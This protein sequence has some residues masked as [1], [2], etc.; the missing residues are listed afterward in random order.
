[1]KSTMQS[2]ALTLTAV[3]HAISDSFGDGQALTCRNEEG[4]VERL[5][6]DELVL[7]TARLA[8][9]L[10]ALNVMRGDRIGTLMWNSGQHLEAYLAIPC[11]GAVLHTLNVRLTAEQLAFVVTDAGDRVVLCDSSLAS[12][13]AAAI[14]AMPTVES[15][16]VVGDL[17]AV[18]RSTFEAAGKTVVDYADA[19]AS[20]ADSYQWP[21]L[22]EH[23]AASL[24]YTSGTTGDPKGVVYSHRSVYLHALAACSGN[25]AGICARDTVMPLVPMFHVNA[26]GLPYAALMAGADLV[27][28]HRFVRPATIAALVEGWK[29]TVAG[30]VP[31]VFNDLLGWLRENPGHDLTSLRRVFCGGAAVPIALI[32]AYRSEFGVTITQAWG[33]TETSPIVCVADPPKGCGPEQARGYAQAAGRVVFGSRGRIVGDDG[34]VLPR[35]GISVGEFQVSGPWITGQYL[36]GRNAES[37]ERSEDGTV[38]LR[39][40]DI[41]RINHLGYVQLTDRAKDVIKSGGE[42]ISSVELETAL[43]GHP[44]VIEAAVIGVPDSRWDERPLAVVVRSH[45]SD[46]SEAELQEWLSHRVVKWWLPERWSFVDAL[47]RTGTGKTDKRALRAR[48]AANDLLVTTLSPGSAF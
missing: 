27:L 7:R 20:A 6:Y 36:G 15:V 3:L 21:L 46:V 45:G 11:Y 16:V 4:D 37:F 47:Q 26:W 25:V 44:A 31:T 24:C 23:S 28:P 40:G 32:D 2:S 17:P 35:D 8:N 29:P 34:Q 18:E 10:S 41:G 39:T 43:A 13:L 22:D 33:M 30:A 14:S 38:W 12:T 42:W 1:M 5:G 9:V 19:L 48:Y